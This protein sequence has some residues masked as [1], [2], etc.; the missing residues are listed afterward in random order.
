MTTRYPTTL[1]GL[2]VTTNPS[3]VAVLNRAAELADGAW[4][5]AFRVAA[6]EADTDLQWVPVPDT[7]DLDFHWVHYYN[8]CGPITECPCTFGA[9]LRAALNLVADQQMA[10]DS[11]KVLGEIAE[12]V[13]ATKCGTCGKPQHPTGLCP[14]W[15]E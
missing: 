2:A 12:Q 4:A 3:P 6:D 13:M 15:F 14:G 7:R 1:A 11:A 5:E 10:E 9:V 8:S